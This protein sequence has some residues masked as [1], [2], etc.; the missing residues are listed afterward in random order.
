[1]NR[2]EFIIYGGE[3]PQDFPTIKQEQIK[4]IENFLIYE[5][6]WHFEK[7][8]E[9]IDYDRLIET[10]A[11]QMDQEGWTAEGKEE[12]EERAPEIYEQEVERLEELLANANGADAGGG[13]NYFD[14]HL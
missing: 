10:V 13:K 12:M 3:G 7:T 9:C 2:E 5:I 4:E 1:M 8:G 6:E 11:Q 14:N